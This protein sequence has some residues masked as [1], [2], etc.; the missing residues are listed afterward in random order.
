MTDKT[1]GAPQETVEDVVLGMREWGNGE[2]CFNDNPEGEPLPCVF[3]TKQ[4]WDALCDRLTL[5][6]RPKFPDLE[7][8][9]VPASSI[10]VV[11]PGEEVTCLQARQIRD[12]ILA[13]KA[14]TE[15]NTRFLMLQHGTTVQVLSDDDLAR[16][17]LQ[18]IP[19]A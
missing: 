17:G 9:N 13:T 11:I 16:I 12:A 2:G 7:I 4:A 19:A 8:T 15:L 18:R 10:V 3:Y 6:S 14:K 5:A 1:A